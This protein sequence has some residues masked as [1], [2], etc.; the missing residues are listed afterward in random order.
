MIGPDWLSSE[1]LKVIVLGL[2]VNGRHVVHRLLLRVWQPIAF[3]FSQILENRQRG[4]LS[5]WD[6]VRGRNH[7]VRELGLALIQEGLEFGTLCFI[8]VYPVQI[9]A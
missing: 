5:R 8:I 2:A 1:F 7:E 3:R 9:Y 6:R 4:R